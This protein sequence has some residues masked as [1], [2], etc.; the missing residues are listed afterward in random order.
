VA[1]SSDVRYVVDPV[2]RDAAFEEAALKAI[3]LV[4]PAVIAYQQATAAVD[5]GRMKASV[6]SRDAKDTQGPYT[7]VGP[8]ATDDRGFPY[9]LAVE[10]GYGNQRAQPFI[11][12]S[13]DVVTGEIG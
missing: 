8:T 3:A 4:V 13:A 1:V 5:T 2:A 11:R 6:S 10:F 7:D 9:P 12:P